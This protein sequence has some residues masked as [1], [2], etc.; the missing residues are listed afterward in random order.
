MREPQTQRATELLRA[1]RAGDERALDDL[2]PL[3][4]DEL[5]ALARRAMSSERRDHTLQPTALVS[6]AYLRLVGMEIDWR[7]RAHFL[8]VAARTMRRLLVDHGRSH[9]R[10]KR[11]GGVRVTL[12]EQHRATDALSVDFLD[13]DRALRRLE[14]QDEESV[15]VLELQ[16]LGGLTAEEVGAVV[17]L[18]RATVERRARFAKAWLY[19]ELRH[20]PE[21]GDSDRP[22]GR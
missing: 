19:R 1:W 4:Y 17:G 3:L 21:R 20:E 8:A 15:R 11:S 9:R 22:S 13:L 7:D 6:E 12:D 14:E 18:S 16:Y 5:R 2:M 10:K